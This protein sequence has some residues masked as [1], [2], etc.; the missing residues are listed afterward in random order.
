M[1]TL[2]RRQMTGLFNALSPFSIPDIN[3][4]K[5]IAGDRLKNGNL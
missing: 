3:L 1:H 5:Q 2:S 4:S